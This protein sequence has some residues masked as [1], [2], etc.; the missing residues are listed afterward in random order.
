MTHFLCFGA[1][2]FFQGSHL[3]LLSGVV[4]TFG[5]PGEVLDVL[6]VVCE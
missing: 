2:L 5:F 3:G 4:L 6:P 1:F